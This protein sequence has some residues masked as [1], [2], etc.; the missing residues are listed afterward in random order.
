MDWKLFVAILIGFALLGAQALFARERMP[1]M[2]WRAGLWLLTWLALI[3]AVSYLGP[4]RAD[5]AHTLSPGS[6]RSRCSRSASP[7]TSSPI[8]RGCR[9]TGSAS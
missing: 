4:Y 3:A 8:A 2:D 6:E 9:V 5:A 7:S 1:R